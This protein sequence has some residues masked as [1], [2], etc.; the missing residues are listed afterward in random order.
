MLLLHADRRLAL[1]GQVRAA[2]RGEPLVGPESQ[3][4]AEIRP[5]PPVG[6]VQGVGARVRRVGGASG[7]KDASRPDKGFARAAAEAL[8]LLFQV[9]GISAGGRPVRHSGILRSL[10]DLVVK[11]GV[12]NDL[13]VLSIDPPTPRQLFHIAGGEEIADLPMPRRSWPGL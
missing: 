2:E 12:R 5:E 7:A 1:T 4:H 9:Q 6:G 10:G 13:D 8:Q 11:D 3:L